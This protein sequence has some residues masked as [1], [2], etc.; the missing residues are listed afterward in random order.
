MKWLFCCCVVDLK[1]FLKCDIC[2]QLRIHTFLQTISWQL[3]KQNL[4]VVHVAKRFHI[5][6]NEVLSGCDHTTLEMTISFEN[7]R[8]M[9]LITLVENNVIHDN[10]ILNELFLWFLFLMFSFFFLMHVQFLFVLK[11]IHLFVLFI[12]IFLFLNDFV[13]KKFVNLLEDSFVDVFLI[14][15]L[16]VIIIFKSGNLL[17]FSSHG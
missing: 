9:L 4:N 7:D 16:N 17:I 5:L 6:M 10:P 12:C 13:F 15:E 8:K 11:D 3:R 1:K 14:E 2:P